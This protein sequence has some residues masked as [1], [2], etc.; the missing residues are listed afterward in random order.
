MGKITKFK[1]H[2][3]FSGCCF[4]SKEM[5]SGNVL[6]ARGRQS[7]LLLEAKCLLKKQSPY[8]SSVLDG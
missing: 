8:L 4:W 6:L 2:L 5:S 1:I 7:E 3:F